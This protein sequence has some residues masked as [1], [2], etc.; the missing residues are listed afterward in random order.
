[1]GEGSFCQSLAPG[2]GLQLARP[3]T[4]RSQPQRCTMPKTINSFVHCIGRIRYRVENGKFQYNSEVGIC[5]GDSIEAEAAD[6]R[7]QATE[8]CL[9]LSNGSSA[10]RFWRACVF[11]KQRPPRQYDSEVLSDESIY[12]AS[13]RCVRGLLGGCISEGAWPISSPGEHVDTGFG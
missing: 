4:P 1:M 6:L 8:R 3:P 11:L 5:P 7:S 2:A 12:S 9:V 10:I 13:L